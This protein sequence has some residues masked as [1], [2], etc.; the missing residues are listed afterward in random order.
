MG[1]VDPVRKEISKSFGIPELVEGNIWLS[2]L[3]THWFAQLS[4]SV[5]REEETKKKLTLA[6]M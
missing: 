2:A 3:N 4:T 6:Y 1:G 5:L